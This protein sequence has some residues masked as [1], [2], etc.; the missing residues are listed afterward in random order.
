MQK[1][2]ANDG[3]VT[4]EVGQIFTDLIPVLIY[5]LN[6]V[7]IWF[8]FL[9]HWGLILLGAVI[10]LIALLL[11]DSI[12]HKK[13]VERRVKRRQQLFSNY[14]VPTPASNPG[15]EI[16]VDDATRDA[17]DENLPAPVAAQLQSDNG[18]YK[19]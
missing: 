19:Q 16:S 8:A 11:Y 14:V 15:N 4:L 9:D 6:T 2:R 3:A 18:A 1:Q 17:A 10:I 5:Y 13:K 7:L 12:R